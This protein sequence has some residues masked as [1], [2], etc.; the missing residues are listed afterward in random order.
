MVFVLQGIH[1]YI[2]LY[3]W[4]RCIT[5]HTTDRYAANL[6]TGWFSWCHS[7]KTW[8]LLFIVGIPS[9][10]ILVIPQSYGV[11]LRSYL[12]EKKT[13][14]SEQELGYPLEC[15]HQNKKKPVDHER[16]I[17][18]FPLNTNEKNWPTAKQAPN[19]API[20]KESRHPGSDDC[21]PGQ[22]PID[23]IEWTVGMDLFCVFFCMEPGVMCFFWLEKQ[24]NK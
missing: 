14:S 8:N 11:L 10:P 7:E 12:A 18:W 23:A 1:I 16:F 4:Y 24:V 9:K 19:D 3:I 2:Y 15:N 21:I 6:S 5:K 22:V 13:S 20:T 17:F